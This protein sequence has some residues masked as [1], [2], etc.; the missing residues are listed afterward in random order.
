MSPQG[1]GKTSPILIVVGVLVLLAV[2]G[3]A[4][5]FVATQ[6]G[7]DITTSPAPAPQTTEPSTTPPPV[8]PPST[9]AGAVTVA[10]EEPTKVKDSILGTEYEITDT[11][12]VGH[13]TS[14]KYK[15][16][17]LLLLYGS[18]GMGGTPFYYFV[19][20]SENQYVSLE[21]Y[22][23]VGSVS[24]KYTIDAT[25]DIPELDFPDTLKGPNGE[26][27]NHIGNMGYMF[28]SSKNDPLFND[29]KWGN[30]Y[31]EKYDKNS[32]VPLQ[33]GFYLRSPDGT[34]QT[35]VLEIPFMK[36]DSNV[37]AL[38]WTKGGKNTNEYTYTDR[39]GCGSSNYFSVI[40][41]Q[42]PLTD[43]VEAGKT[44]QGE[45]IYEFKNSNHTFLKK[46]Y[47]ENYVVYGDITKKS[48]ADFIAAHPVFFWKDSFGRTIKF[49][50]SLFIPQAECGKPV[51]YLY[52]EKTT[53]V[54][55]KLDPKGGFSFTE[56][57]YNNGWNV[58]ATPQGTLTEISS[59]KS[60]PY[61]FWEGRGGIYSSPTKGFSVAQ[62]DVHGFLVDKLHAL[63]LNDKETADFI[64]F[65]EPRMQGSPYYFV[66]FYGNKVM[67]ELAPLTVTP[68]PDTVIRVLMD[69]VP[70]QGPVKAE[71]FKIY[72]PARTGFTVVEWG[73]V[74]R[75]K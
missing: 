49:E 43:L 48:Y 64:E 12:K 35:Y 68:K 19:K 54:S 7:Q 63:G 34:T 66:S 44:T 52:P 71:E 39:N 2:G 33:N 15:D 74:L 24:D 60:Y 46:M 50:N 57:A 4:G 22:S 41:D 20:S 13:F 59:G 5:Y 62:K 55:V 38:T 42:F 69:F 56:P 29:P 36:K 30:V 73:G 21:R 45:S 70:V 61:L 16:G 53:N 27:L 14:G 18:P 9:S 23:S 65:W 26:I 6:K 32:D 11:Y 31:L 25:F 3:A 10:W 72:T 17:D 1:S 28:G 67:D 75:G 8:T 37:P 47:D 40:R 51:I 58:T